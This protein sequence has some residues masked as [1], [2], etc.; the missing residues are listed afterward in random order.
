M[1][2]GRQSFG[3][4]RWSD[5]HLDRLVG[6]NPTDGVLE[7]SGQVHAIDAAGLCAP[8]ESVPMMREGQF[9]LGGRLPVNPS[10]GTLCTNAIAVT[11]MARVAETAAVRE[12]FTPQG[13]E[14]T[15]TTPVEFGAYL[16]SEVE[17]WGKVVKASGAKPE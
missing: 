8:G 12:Q 17:K 5:E 16:K 9:E 1:D 11:A 4:H 10:G 7:R 3:V 6:E 15:H 13:I 14:A 2:P